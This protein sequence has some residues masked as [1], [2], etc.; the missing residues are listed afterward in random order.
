MSESG[1]SSE[2]SI[3]VME[4]FESTVNEVPDEEALFYE[5]EGK[6]TG[7]SW[8][9]YHKYVIYFAKALI[10]VGIKP[11]QT[12]NILGFNSPEW[13]IAY[14]G[15]IFA[16]APPVGIYPTNSSDM[17]VYIAESS[18]C[19]CLV[20]D[21]ILHYRKYEQE[22]K[23]LKTLKVVIFYCDL[24]ESEIKSLINPYVS[25]YLWKDFINLG[26]KSTIDME[27]SSRVKMQKP[28]NCCTLI[29]TSGTTDIPK[30]VM[31]SHD[32]LTWT[33]KAIYNNYTHIIGDKQ[34][35]I[36]FLPLSHIAGQMVD[37][38]CNYILL[39]LIVTMITKSQVYFA[40]PDAMSGSLV[41][42]MR[43][44]KPTLFFGVPR[45]FEKFEEKIREV[46]ESSM[47][48]KRK[49]I[50]WSQKVGQKAVNNKFSGGNPPLFYKIANFFIFSRVREAL[51]FN[52]REKN[53]QSIKYFKNLLNFIFI[54]FS[55]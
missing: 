9:Q 11:F 55:N 32:N 1:I 20:V 24:N 44:I 17:C 4:M 46:I 28:G 39:I 21:D 10:S 31:L 23:K 25:I 7:I 27:L 2:K 16:C 41:E 6:F 3:T 38:F 51:G 37:I 48:I 22:L 29:Y 13:F 36:S 8:N 30:G 42:T 33:V 54:I 15:G 45:I 18:E 53:L 52:I 14:I 34:R 43:K 35:F 40:N 12:I 50:K 49:I 26:K 5:K 19:G 47:L